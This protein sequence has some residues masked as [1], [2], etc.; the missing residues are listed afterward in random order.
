LLALAYVFYAS[1]FDPDVG[2]PSLIANA[3]IIVLSLVYYAIVLRRGV[4]WTL[5]GPEEDPHMS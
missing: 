2:W 5:R 4:G 3:A 1:A